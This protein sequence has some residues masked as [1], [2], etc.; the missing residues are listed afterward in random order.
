MVEFNNER[1]YLRELAKRYLEIANLPVMKEREA[2]WY[3]HNACEAERPIVVMEMGT[4]EGDILPRH[5]CTSPY[6]QRMEYTLLRAILNHEL[7][8]DDKV[9]S[10]VFEVPLDISIIPFGLEMSRTFATDSKG[11][12]LGYKDVHPIN[13]LEEDFEKL[14]ASVCRFDAEATRAYKQFVLDTLGDLMPVEETNHSMDWFFTISQHVINLM[15]MEALMYALYDV[16]DM[17]QKLYH[18]IADDMISVLDWQ[19]SNGLLR[20]NTGNHYAGS[21]SYGFTNELPKGNPVTRNM[22]WGNLNSQETVSI[23]PAMFHEFIYPA[24]AKV[25]EQ[26]ALTYYGCCEPVHTIW[27]DIRNLP[28]LRKVSIS[29]WCDE[30][31]MGEVL[32]GGKVIYSRKPSPNYIGVG[33]DLDEDAYTKHIDQTLKCAKGCELEIIHRDIYTLSGNTAKAGRAVQIIRKEIDRLW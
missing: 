5:K 12:R 16:P 22:I 8:D 27:E 19:E 26:F 1:T 11:Q 21:G 4:F 23:S 15:G 9:V 25:A 32:Q 2:L 6:G 33:S 17:V 13:D 7:I 3:R 18:F 29:P 30:S 24:Y 10:P 14:G 31:F 28:H 20:L